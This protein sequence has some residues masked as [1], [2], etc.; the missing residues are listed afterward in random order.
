MVDVPLPIIQYRNG[1]SLACVSL[2]MIPFTSTPSEVDEV[3]ARLEVLGNPTR[4]QIFRALVR[5][6]GGG[7]SV[8]QL[9]RRLGSIAAS[10]LSHHLN[11]LMVVGLVTRQRQGTT[12]ICRAEYPVMHRLVGFLSDECCSDSRSGSSADQEIETAS[13][14]RNPSAA[15]T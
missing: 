7:L 6:G 3:A 14:C 10:T 1:Y 12:L 13:G 4:L 2:K 9:Q 11:R 15:G 8:G 5:A